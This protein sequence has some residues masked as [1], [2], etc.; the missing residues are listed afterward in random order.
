MKTYRIDRLVGEAYV[1]AL[2]YVA[3][4]VKR[5]HNVNYTIKEHASDLEL[6]ARVL[7]WKFNEN[8]ERVEE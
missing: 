1:T 4:Y 2:K 6:I 3:D 7:E 5:N 8:G